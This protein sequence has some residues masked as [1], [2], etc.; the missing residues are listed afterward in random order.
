MSDEGS[1]AITSDSGTVTAAP[2]GMDLDDGPSE[3]AGST[4]SRATRRPR[5]MPDAQE[6]SVTAVSTS[7]R[8][9]HTH[10]VSVGKMP[11]SK[12]STPSSFPVAGQSSASSSSSVR[13]QVPLVPNPPF[14]VIRTFKDLVTGKFPFDIMKKN[15]AFLK[16]HSDG[17]LHHLGTDELMRIKENGGDI[18]SC[19]MIDMNQLPFNTVAFVL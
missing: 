16:A 7:K 10:R 12:M 13:D 11:A 15:L 9:G 14:I 17:Y 8:R 1:G 3:A 2:A 19:F 6:S 5:V 4:T 18:Y